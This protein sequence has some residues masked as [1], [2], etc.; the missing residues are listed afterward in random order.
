[1]STYTAPARTAHGLI[2]W[3]LFGW[4]WVALV[5]ISKV[6]WAVLLFA[7]LV[8]WA[9]LTFLGR[10]TL[11]VFFWPLGLWSSIA[12]GRNVHDAKMRRWAK[13]A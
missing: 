9:V 1:M 4:W 5:F 6:T 13:H 7:L 10:V 2:Y 8:S 3:I 11:W 12:H